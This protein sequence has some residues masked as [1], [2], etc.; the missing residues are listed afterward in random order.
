MESLPPYT[1]PPSLAAHLSIT[2]RAVPSRPGYA[3]LA[4]R[5]ET[6]TAYPKSLPVKAHKLAEAGFCYA[7]CLDHVRCF[8]CGVGVKEWNLNEDPWEE[9]VRWSPQCGF[10]LQSKG[11][12][13][14]EHV[15]CM[16]NLLQKNEVSRSVILL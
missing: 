10:V 15:T 4:A 12:A 6:F 7:G 1:L 9:H 2:Q 16:F 13:Y 14:V 5:M 3:S 11:R 8:Y